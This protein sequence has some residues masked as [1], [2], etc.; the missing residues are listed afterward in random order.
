MDA[1]F[2]SNE[3]PFYGKERQNVVER[4]AHWGPLTAKEKFLLHRTLP[5]DSQR[6][7]NQT[8]RRLRCNGEFLFRWF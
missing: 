6:T 3:H 1:V 8:C 5:G 2:N 7:D 4:S